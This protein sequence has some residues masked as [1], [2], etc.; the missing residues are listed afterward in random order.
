VAKKELLCFK[1]LW[2]FVLA[3]HDV[4][5]GAAGDDDLREAVVLLG[6][7]IMVVVHSTTSQLN[8]LGPC[9]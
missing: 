3:P 4:V 8:G 7:I 1:M 2:H 6:F 5:I 9:G